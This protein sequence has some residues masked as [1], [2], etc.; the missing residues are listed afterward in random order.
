MPAEKKGYKILAKNKKARFNYEI[1]EKFE[2]GIE[3]TGTEVKSVRN[4]RINIS[5]GF[6][7]IDN[8]EC[9]LKQVHIS[10]YKEGNIFNEDPMR[11]RKLLLH[12][13]E[14]KFLLGKTTLLGY[15]I[16]PLCVYLKHGLIKVEIAL[17]KGKKL[18]DKRRDM[19]KRDAERK[20]ERT[21]KEYNR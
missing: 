2:A 18:H 17:C 9:F 7:S 4:G 20:I 6:V 5:D 10:P 21:L 19:A 16:V 15:S 12:K 8:S 14:I 13:R 1:I 3:L 11:I